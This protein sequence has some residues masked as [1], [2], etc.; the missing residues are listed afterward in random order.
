VEDIC[1]W[2]VG[3]HQDIVCL[4]V[5]ANLP[6]IDEYTVKYFLNR[7]VMNLRFRADFTDEVNWSLYPEGVAF[8]LSFHHN[9]HTDDVS[10][11]GDVE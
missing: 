4:K 3:D 8:F 1:Q 6:R 11:R 7:W 9:C 10:S 2:E 5:V